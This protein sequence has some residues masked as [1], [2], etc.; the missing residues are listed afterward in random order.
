M[1][2]LQLQPTT[3]GWLSLDPR[4]NLARWYS[5]WGVKRYFSSTLNFSAVRRTVC[6]RK[7][8]A[9]WRTQGERYNV[10]EEKSVG[11]NRVGSLAI[12]TEFLSSEESGCWAKFH[13]ALY[14]RLSR[15]PFFSK[16]D[17]WTSE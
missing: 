7:G 14:P 1:D 17:P 2:Q 5:E 9:L 15:E 11:S 13:P 3:Q 12:G 6:R 4:V 10:R 8:G 16:F